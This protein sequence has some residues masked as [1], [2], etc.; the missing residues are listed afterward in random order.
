[1]DIHSIRQTLRTKSIYDIPLRVTFYAR[2]S[3]ESDEQLNSLGNQVSYYEEFIRKSSAWEYVPGYVD[4]GLSAATTKK[5]ED[6]HR[7]V[8]DGRAGLFD[9]IITKEI[10]RFARNTLD[11]ILYTR[12][13]LGAG[14]GVFFQNDNINTFDEDSELR[15]TI[16][17]GIAQ[18][19]L[20]KLSSRVKFGHAQ[21]IK[22]NVVL[23]NSR[24]FGYVKDGGRL[25]IDEEEAPMVRSLFELY[26]TGEYSMKQIETLFWER[27][28]RNHN[29]RRIAHTTMSGIISNPKYKGYYV[30]NK[31]KVVDLFTKKQKFLPPEEWVMFK[32]ETGEIVPAIVSEALWDQA[33]AVL[34]KRSED[35]KGRQGICNHA[36][37][38]TGKLYCTHC[39]AAYYRRESAD[40]QG[41][42]NSKWVC[43]GKIKNGADSCPSFP[44]YEE[45]LKPLLF[46][47][48]SETEADAEA[49]A[50]EYIEMY[51]ALDG[52]SGAA[53]QIDALRRQIALAQK[54]RSKLLGYNAAGQLSDR[55]FLS[56]NKDCEREISEAERQ[57]YDLEQQQLSREGFR[58]QIDT[59]RRVL[60]E[61][62]RDAPRGLISK[63]FIDKYIDKILVTPEEDGSLRLQIKVFT[64]ETT[65]KYLAHLRSR[66]GHTFKKM[67]ESYE[68]NL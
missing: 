44:I 53:A 34:K 31:V 67:I 33:N 13:L 22:K 61:A 15:L 7:M 19:E 48:F 36:N 47:V 38:L 17:S 24:I 5:R 6:F 40:R 54:K 64:G 26:A 4:E 46:Q 18:D 37:L 8:E 16:M 50:A 10:T 68:K 65:D 52:G 2:V 28:Y 41:R 21:A 43:S 29:G 1:M 57:I 9:L 3:S 32:D 51:K 49:L 58:K 25:V 12:E 66:T 30:G 35:V 14:V 11:S 39:G 62:R 45:E 23:G 55:D 42:K 27:G 56:M 63:E 59:I 60:N 20:R